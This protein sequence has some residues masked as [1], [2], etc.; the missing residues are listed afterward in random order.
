ME[1][2]Q[3]ISVQNYKNTFINLLHRKTN[4]LLELE[5]VIK[6]RRLR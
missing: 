1:Q 5:V 2:Q 4:G 6:A 3:N